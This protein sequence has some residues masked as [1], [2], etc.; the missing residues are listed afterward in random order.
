MDCET[1]REALSARLD[2]EAEPAPT[3][4]VDAH[5]G[6]C[7]TCAQW[8][9]KAEHLTRTIRVRPAE[10]PPDLVD[11]VLAVRPKPTAL[12]SRV[13]LVVV[14]LIQVWLAMAQF[15]TGATG[16]H[17][18]H[19]LTGHDL[20]S[21]LF[22]EGA[23]WNLALGIGLLV[24]AVQAHRA[25]GLLPTLS[26]FVG[27]LLLFSA[28]DIIAGSAT[29]I[30]VVSH[31]PLLAGLALLYLVARAHRR[32]PTPGTPAVEGDQDL[33]PS[34]KPGDWAPNPRKHRPRHLR[35]T[36]HRRAA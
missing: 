2:G 20:A 33:G 9:A 7:P 25:T 5:L 29:A 28:H 24:A 36:A 22:N 11:A 12:G 19:E 27:I 26:G 1:C 32:E 15:L 13:A 34:A 30:R 14:A 18:G 17:A 23:A 3:A 21:H 35:P 31:G 8:Q 10:Q 4:D 16:D 6:Q